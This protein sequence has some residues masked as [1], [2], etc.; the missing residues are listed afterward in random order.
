MKPRFSF[1]RRDAAFVAV[2]GAVLVVLALGSGKRTTPATP[3]DP[4]HQQATSRAACL[5]CHGKGGVR[6]MPK[7]HPKMDQCFM[8]HAPPAHWV[9][10]R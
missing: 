10:K 7:R 2:V 3:D 4:P 5:G 8:C 1:T 9:G 6:A